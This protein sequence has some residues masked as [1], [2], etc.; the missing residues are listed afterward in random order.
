MGDAAVAEEIFKAPAAGKVKKLGDALK[1]DKATHGS[2][3]TFAYEK[4]FA[5]NISKYDSHADLRKAIF[6]SAP[7]TLLE[8]SPHNVN[9]G[10]GLSVDDPKIQNCNE[11]PGENKFGQLLTKLSDQ[12]MA[13]DIYAQEVEAINKERAAADTPA[14]PRL[15]RNVR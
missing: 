5:A 10:V 1:W 12:M 14:K 9:W 4:L 7:L 3:H 15:V 6:E 13:L 8:A 11:R 2:W